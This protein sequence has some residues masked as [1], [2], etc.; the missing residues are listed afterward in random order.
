MK[1]I[2]TIFAF[3]FYIKRAFSYLCFFSA[4]ESF[5]AAA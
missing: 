4:P 5:L 1:I 2:K 3:F